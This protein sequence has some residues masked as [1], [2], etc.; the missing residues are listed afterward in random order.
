MRGE[1]EAVRRGGWV[2]GASGKYYRVLTGQFVSVPHLSTLAHP[3]LN[4]VP[5]VLCT[6][7]W[8]LKTPYE[9]APTCTVTTIVVIYSH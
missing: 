2:V 9:K 7:R 1:W 4:D 8:R 5:N 6:N 3:P